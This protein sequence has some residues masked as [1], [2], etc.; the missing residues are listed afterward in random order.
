M[1]GPKELQALLGRAKLGALRTNF[2]V[3]AVSSIVVLGFGLYLWILTKYPLIYGID[4]PYYLIQIEGLLQSGAL[5]YEDP[6]LAFYLLAFFSVLMGEATLG[7]KVGTALFSALSAIPMYLLIKEVTK[8]R[9]VA[10]FGM[11]ALIL[12]ASFV[13]MMGDLIKNAIGV[14]FLLFF[15][16]CLHRMTFRGPTWRNILL[17]LSFLVLIALCH[18]LDFAVAAFFLVSYFLLSMALGVNRRGVAKGF[19]ILSVA[20]IALI[21]LG[22][23]LFSE[24][25]AHD[26]NKAFSFLSSI[27]DPGALTVFPLL[28]RAPGPPIDGLLL[29]LIIALGMS[30]ALYETKKRNGEAAVLLWTMTILAIL[31]TLPSDNRWR[32]L[33]MEFIPIATILSF[34]AS[35]PLRRVD[36]IPFVLISLVLLGGQFYPTAQMVG[37]TINDHE[38]Q[39]LQE[40]K[41]IVP[42]DS[43]V[44]N[45]A[46]GPIIYWILYVFESW[47]ISGGPPPGEQGYEVFILMQKGVPRPPPPSRGE[48]VFDGDTFILFRTLRPP[49]TPRSVSLGI[50]V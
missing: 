31:L 34:V 27:T 20:L 17:T 23:L 37:P 8:K 5:V 38:Y 42:S 16:Y 30:L 21:A 44:I 22:Y 33:L 3:L 19:G 15:V 9:Y 18:I 48:V 6:P 10:Y 28:P 50:G 39:E 7:I 46:R 25:L 41:S 2:E 36:A 40:M 12:S 11:V 4:G 49:P 26:L 13:R 43:L 35:K 47:K 29:L 14:F 1:V 24:Y 45:R 32:F